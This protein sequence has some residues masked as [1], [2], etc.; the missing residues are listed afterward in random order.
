MSDYMSVAVIN[1]ESCKP[2]IAFNGTATHNSLSVCCIKTAQSIFNAAK[3]DKKKKKTPFSIFYIAAHYSVETFLS[4][5]GSDV[6][7]TPALP[8]SVITNVFG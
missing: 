4:N 3:H 6:K 8:Q 5:K 7:L 2:P 1:C